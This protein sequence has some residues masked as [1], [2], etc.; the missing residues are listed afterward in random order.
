MTCANRNCRK[1]FLNESEDGNDD[2]DDDGNIKMND[3]NNDTKIKQQRREYEESFE[4]N[5]YEKQRGKRGRFGQHM[6]ETRTKTTK[7]TTMPTQSDPSD[8]DDDEDEIETNINIYED[9]APFERNFAPPC[10]SGTIRTEEEQEDTRRKKSP[11]NA[12]SISK[13]K[14]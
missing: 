13:T 12:F 14:P 8:D 1:R 2:L 11:F 6:K 10:E 7:A 9:E 5:V 3:I 4:I